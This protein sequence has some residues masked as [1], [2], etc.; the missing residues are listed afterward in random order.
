MQSGTWCVGSMKGGALYRNIASQKI[1]ISK[2]RRVARYLSANFNSSMGKVVV[3][4]RQ[5][6][7]EN[8]AI[9]LGVLKSKTPLS[10]FSK[11]A[12]FSGRLVQER[13]QQSNRRR[14][15]HSE[16]QA[17]TKHQGN[18]NR[19]IRIMTRY[20]HLT[21]WSCYGIATNQSRKNNDQKERRYIIGFV[22]LGVCS[23]F[24]FKLNSCFSFVFGISV[25]VLYLLFPFLSNILTKRF[26]FLFLWREIRPNESSP[27]PAPTLLSSSSFSLS[28]CSSSFLCPPSSLLP[29]SSSS[30]SSAPIHPFSPFFR[31]LFFFS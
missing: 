27:P 31:I 5:K 3:V 20:Y 30:C 2:C 19:T 24:S 15:F 25:F 29:P 16:Q 17:K 18:A 28:S 10:A 7:A 8:I 11:L 23:I 6:K 12:M 21:G 14:C 13:H 26:Y 22:D 9:F 4:Y 1:A